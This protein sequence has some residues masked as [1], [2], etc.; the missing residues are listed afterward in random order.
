MP[1]REARG[2]GTMRSAIV[3]HMAKHYS[4]GRITVQVTTVS[5]G[6]AAPV[7]ETPLLV[8]F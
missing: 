3:L 2:K 7:L 6:I 5:F 4:S 1:A 8:D